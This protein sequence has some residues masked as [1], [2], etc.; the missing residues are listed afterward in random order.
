M[1]L[2][3][4]SLLSLNP[5]QTGKAIIW[6]LT[7]WVLGILFLYIFLAFFNTNWPL[8]DAE[9]WLRTTVI[10]KPFPPLIGIGGRFYPLGHMAYNWVIYFPFRKSLIPYLLQNAVTLLGG[11]GLLY[12]AMP[13]RNTASQIVCLCSLLFILQAPMMGKIFM[14]IIYPEKNLYVLLP[15]FLFSLRYAEKQKTS[16]LRYILALLPLMLATYTKEPVFVISL[17]YGL[18]RFLF[19]RDTKAQKLFNYLLIFNAIV[20]LILYYLWAYT[21]GPNYASVRQT[22][23]VWDTTQNMIFKWTYG[24]I[25][26]PLFWA[27]FR[28]YRFVFRGDR[29][30]ILADM[31]LFGGFAYIACYWILRFDSSTYS[32]YLYIPG[33]ILV[34]YAINNYISYYIC[35][36]KVQSKRLKSHFPLFI[37]IAL[38]GLQLLLYI[39]PM[40]SSNI[41]DA[42]QLIRSKEDSVR[43]SK[44]LSSLISKGWSIYI[45]SHQPPVKQAAEYYA[46]V[47]NLG[48][49]INKKKKYYYKTP[50][51]IQA[52]EK[53]PKEDF[54]YPQKSLI[55][56]D[57]YRK[58]EPLDPQLF[59]F[60]QADMAI[61]Y[62]G[63]I[64][65]KIS[66]A[67]SIGEIPTEFVEKFGL[68]PVKL[69]PPEEKLRSEPQTSE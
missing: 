20:F 43:I 48:M 26:L 10:G 9:A 66:E 33:F 15:W 47:F 37:V 60:S 13:K 22:G 38:I 16:Y 5:K 35:L 53:S 36:A 67:Y 18:G 62:L 25:I 44:E 56:F 65:I 61:Y 39:L 63:R 45:V 24:I 3:V 19:C 40:Q 42:H 28:C 57:Q 12:F 68:N 8:N 31:L 29:N 52:L 58:I 55:L 17:V 27:V 6:V 30:F 59:E 50:E 46:R 49:M 54:R 14:D 21:P 2:F 41:S 11:T 34:F 23:T 1:A 69:P 4:C 64:D 7:T 51:Y 32:R